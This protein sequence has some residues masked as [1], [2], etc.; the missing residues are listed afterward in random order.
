MKTDRYFWT[1][2]IVTSALI[3]L[4]VIGYRSISP[5]FGP[6]VGILS[7][8]PVSIGGW[9]L[10]TW[11][12]LAGSVILIGCNY[13]LM[14]Y[15][16]IVRLNQL[17][18]HDFLLIAVLL[19]AAGLLFGWL[20]D[21]QKRLS[22]EVNSHRKLVLN[23][24]AM[25][26]KY[27]SIIQC[28]PA[29]VFLV[30]DRARILEVNPSA[31]NLTGYKSDGL[32]KYQLGDLV[33]LDQKEIF[34][35]MWKDFQRNEQADGELA[36]TRS[37][38]QPLYIEYRVVKGNKSGMNL[39]IATDIT[40][41]KQSEMLAQESEKR[42]A[43]MFQTNLALGCII[44]QAGDVILDITPGFT[45]LVGYSRDE[46]IGKTLTELDIWVDL[47]E[48][49]KAVAKP[50]LP[51]S[52]SNKPIQFR[53]KSGETGDGLFSFEPINYQSKPCIL[54]MGIDATKTALEED[55]IH[56][57]KE[58]VDTILSSAPIGIMLV[59][60]RCIEWLNDR[61]QEM[62][63]Y[64]AD[65]LIGQDTRIL[66]PTRKEYELV[67][68]ELYC[69][70]GRFGVGQ[71]DTRWV[72]RDGMVMDV[73][74]QVHDLDKEDIDKGQIVAVVDITERKRVEESLRYMSTHDT[75]T[76][77]YNRAYFEE[78][79]TRLAKS[80]H[81]PLSFLIC[82]VDGLKQTNDTSGHFIGDKLLITAA[83]ALRA[84]FRDEDIIAR[85][86][87]D[88]FIVLLPDTGE[89][90]ADL[91]IDRIHNELMKIAQQPGQTH[92]D[93]SIGFASA[94]NASEIS[95]ARRRAD[96]RMYQDKVFHKSQN[97]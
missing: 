1:K 31:C 61:L 33:D 21:S 29:A 40:A 19:L 71:I 68:K 72:R 69:E 22:C 47:Q 10:G 49:R 62:V 84:A 65:Q 14:D 87:G 43:K 77:L 67:G 15:N 90:A 13:F 60:N 34:A 28:N 45:R 52:L 79:L 63:S 44:E 23:L 70:S 92:V 12:G 94:R 5:I 27:E 4:Y 6:M 95:A 75:L 39:F 56:S 86:G 85:L 16:D 25:Q 41:R 66:Y 36:L 82:D 2:L 81:F 58:I 54:C 73:H 96:Q 74:L 32:L 26:A 3:L 93:L 80:R 91:I 76:G 24:K 35:Q 46:A 17:G 8:L 57:R 97:N 88:E 42:L 59:R 37:D 38:H 11:G 20:S 53:K 51:A 7:T 50:G 55:I 18:V 48:Y 83:Q 9:L 89:D 78:E 30:D 64:S